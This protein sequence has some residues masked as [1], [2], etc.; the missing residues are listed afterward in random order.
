MPLRSITWDFTRRDFPPR[1]SECAQRAAPPSRSHQPC[2]WGSAGRCHC[3]YNNRDPFLPLHTSRF[4][5]RF[6]I[7]HL[8]YRQFTEGIPGPASEGMTLELREGQQ[9]GRVAQ[10]VRA[11]SPGLEQRL[12]PTDPRSLHLSWGGGRGAQAWGWA[13]APPHPHPGSRPPRAGPRQG[14]IVSWMEEYRLPPKEK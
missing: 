11:S 9:L 13:W 6:C 7:Q 10:L 3:R 12:P 14:G 8:L 2:V 4:T 1:A 5:Q